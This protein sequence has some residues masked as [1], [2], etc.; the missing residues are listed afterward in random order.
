MDDL[1]GSRDPTIFEAQDPRSRR[2]WLDRE[3]GSQHLDQ[4]HP[5]QEVDQGS[6]ARTR[7]R[8]LRVGEGEQALQRRGVSAGVDVNHFRQNAQ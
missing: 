1:E 5:A 4:Q 7:R 8:R 6:G 3:L 2:T